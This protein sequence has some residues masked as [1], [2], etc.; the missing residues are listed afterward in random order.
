MFDLTST[1][2]PVE[3]KV[4]GEVKARYVLKLID[5]PGALDGVSKFVTSCA[6]R[7]KDGCR[8]PSLR[9]FQ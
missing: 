8:C 3:F 1:G 6:P 9:G 5:K 4:G 7:C 2:P